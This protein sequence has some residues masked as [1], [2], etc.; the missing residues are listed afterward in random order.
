MTKPQKISL[1]LM[2]YGDCYIVKSVKGTSLYRI[3]DDVDAQGI[4][5][6]TKNGVDISIVA[7]PPEKGNRKGEEEVSLKQIA[8]DIIWGYIV[9]FVIAAIILSQVQSCFR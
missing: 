6:L 3:G 5:H 7:P 2:D 4:E 8:K 1:T 9:A